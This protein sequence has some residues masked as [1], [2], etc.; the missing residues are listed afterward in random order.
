MSGTPAALELGN[1][2]QT[3]S[4]LLRCSS[5]KRSCL[6]PPM[7]ITS[8]RFEEPWDIKKIKEQLK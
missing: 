4:S 7:H 8:R 2:A 5:K 1:V 6:W 3:G